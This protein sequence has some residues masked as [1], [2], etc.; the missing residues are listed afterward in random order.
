MLKQKML[1]FEPPD[2]IREELE[3]N[4]RYSKG[5]WRRETLNLR[6]RARSVYRDIK[7]GRFIKKP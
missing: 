2:F 7:T 6:G 3:D 4:R 1:G 5:S